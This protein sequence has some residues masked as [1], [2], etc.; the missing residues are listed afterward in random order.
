MNYLIFLKEVG[1]LS[2]QFCYYRRKR[3]QA[4]EVMSA[5]EAH[6]PKVIGQIT[7]K[8]HI[9]SVTRVLENCPNFTTA[10]DF[11]HRKVIL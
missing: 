3:Q 11:S 4:K 5:M 2:Q 7:S 10:F 9:D 1:Q 8:K 6:H